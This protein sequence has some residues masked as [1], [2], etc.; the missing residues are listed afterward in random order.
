MPKGGFQLKG[1]ALSELV[2]P[3]TASVPCVAAQKGIALELFG[4][5]CPYSG[6]AKKWSAS[7]PVAFLH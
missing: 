6:V 2:A 4:K 5:R 1:R 3:V 7:M